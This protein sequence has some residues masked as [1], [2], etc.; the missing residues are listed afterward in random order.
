MGFNFDAFAAFTKGYMKQ[1]RPLVSEH[2]RDYFYLAPLMMTYI[3]GI[4]FLADY[5]NGDVY[6]KTAYPDHN[7]VRT[8]TQ[9]KL[10]ESMEKRKAGHGAGDRGG[11]CRAG[12]ENGNH[13]KQIPDPARAPPDQSVQAMEGSLQTKQTNKKKK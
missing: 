12:I 11:A 1:V 4:R 2:E 8:K 7:L 6:Y 5:L 9:K 10:I 3:I 13:D